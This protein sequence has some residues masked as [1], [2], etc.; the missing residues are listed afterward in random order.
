MKRLDWYILKKFII[1][2]SFS[3]LILTIITIVIDLSER[4]DDFV[5]SGLNARQ[6]LMQYYAGFIPHIVAMIFP[7][8]VFI[9]VIFFTSKMASRSEIIA[10]LASG[11]SYRRFLWPYWMASGLLAVI[12]FWAFR[13]TVPDANKIYSAFQVKYMDDP[14]TFGP[15]SSSTSIYFRVDSNRYA[16]V[17]DFDTSS[18]AGYNF[19]LQ[20]IIGNQLTENFRADRIEWNKSKQL[21]KLTNIVDRKIDG[22]K[23]TL[24]KKDSMFMQFNFKPGD[25]KKDEYTKDRLTTPELNQFIKLQEM[26]GAEGINDL[27]VERQRRIATPVSIILLTFIG[28]TVSSRKVR[29]GMGYHL[30]IGFISAAIFILADRFSTIFSTKGNLSPELAAWLPN[31]IFLF[32]SMY[33]YRKAPK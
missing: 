8:F 5:K 30:A 12:L 7:L 29:G 20:T 6:L 2:F 9:S 17:S 18:K 32:I 19:V 1:T 26:R 27:L 24:S 23:E 14:N 13:F 31:I 15:Y 33:F 22:L 10:I 21:W 4:A 16:H 28:V 25:I 11:V 3:L